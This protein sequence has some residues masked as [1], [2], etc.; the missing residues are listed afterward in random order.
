MYDPNDVGGR[1]ASG[2][3]IE[4][5]AGAVAESTKFLIP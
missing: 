4:S 5:N 1:I 3:A 2:S